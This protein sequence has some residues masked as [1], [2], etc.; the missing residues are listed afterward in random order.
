MPLRWS[1]RVAKKVVNRPPAVV[2]AQNLLMRKLG[3]TSSSSI[4]TQDF[5]HYIKVFVDGLT[6][7]QSN[8]IDVDVIFMLSASALD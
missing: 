3:L 6:V 8:L 7:E 1:V 2:V 4:E 5:D